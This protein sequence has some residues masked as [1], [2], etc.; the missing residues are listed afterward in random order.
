MLNRAEIIGRLTHEPELGYTPQGTAFCQLRVATNRRVN[1]EQ[2]AE[3]HTVVTWNALAEQCANLVKGEVVYV[4]GRI[5][6]STWDSAG[7]TRQQTRIVAGR[8]VF[9]G[10]GHQMNSSAASADLASHQSEPAPSVEA[11]PARRSRKIA[12]PPEMDGLAS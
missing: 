12:A 8:V 5:E 3:F 2:I 11:K 10:R 6:T 9:L 1:G 7:A 4:D